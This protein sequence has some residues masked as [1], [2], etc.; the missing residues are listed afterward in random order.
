MTS[1][2]CSSSKLI[3]AVEPW[4]SEPA[5][6]EPPMVTTTVFGS[7]CSTTIEPPPVWASL[8]LLGVTWA[9]RE[10]RTIW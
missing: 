7:G 8:V 1:S 3:S 10:R 9:W 2:S 5:T 4:K 6:A